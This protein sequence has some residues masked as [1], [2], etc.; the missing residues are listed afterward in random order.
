[1]DM[2]LIRELFANC[3]A[4]S[5]ELGIDHS[6]AAKLREAIQRLTP[7][8][9]G[10]NGQLQEWSVDFEEC[11]PGQRHLSPLYPL[12]PGNQIS[13]R[14][15]PELAIA[16][17]KLLERRLAFGSGYTGWSRAW[18]IALW[19]R[20]QDGDEAWAS[21][22]SLLQQN[23][24]GALL[25]TLPTGNGVIFQID[26]NFG[27][28]AAIAELL[29]QSHDGSIDLLPALP[30]FWPSGKV[31][32]LRARGGLSV[33]LQWARGQV[34]RCTLRPDRT[35]EFRIRPPAFQTITAIEAGHKAVPFKQQ[36][37]GSVVSILEGE[38]VHGLVFGAIGPLA[39]T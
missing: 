9:I 38:R 28:T 36:L 4:A 32:G 30:S 10:R 14:K 34:I 20:L 35:A 2:A 22:S 17:R 8:R 18:V 39:A 5:Q 15:T 16:S 24:K 27:A 23:T 37:D 25:D 29:L 31:T 11:T 12:Y 3:I 21:I 1:M 33:D 26:G 6:F 19:S 13:P 7:Y